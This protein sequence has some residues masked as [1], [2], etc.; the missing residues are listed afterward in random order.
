MFSRTVTLVWKTCIAFFCL[1]HAVAIAVYTIP[2]DATGALVD[3]ARTYVRPAVEPYLLLTSQWQM[4]ELFSP[5]P[6]RRVTR[7]RIDIRMKDGEWRTLRT[8]EPATAPVW[9]SDEYSYVQRLEDDGDA[10]AELWTRYARS[11]CAPLGLREGTPVRIVVEY[12]ILPEKPTNGQW[13]FWQR[14]MRSRW[15]EWVAAV[16]PCPAPDDPGVIPISFL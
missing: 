3:A 9:R 8:L 16:A 4:W 7:Y 11:T 6:I 5:N 2:V 12:L 10:F 14:T 15:D 13:S 1:W